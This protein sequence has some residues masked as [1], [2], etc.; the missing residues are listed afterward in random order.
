M[1]ERGVV[2][3]DGRNGYGDKSVICKE[4]GYAACISWD[5]N[6]YQQKLIFFVIHKFKPLL[7]LC[8]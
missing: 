7:Q 6:E 8:Q 3:G 2:L 4:V 1:T 5:T